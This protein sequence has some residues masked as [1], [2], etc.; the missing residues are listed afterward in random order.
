MKRYRTIVADP[1]WEYQ[2]GF[3]GW[4]R[5]RG[6]PYRSMSLEDIRALPVAEWLERE[7]YLFLWATSRHLEAAFSVVRA[8]NCTPRQTLTWCKP[9]DGAKGLGGMFYTNTEF[10]VVAQHIRA[11]TN[12]HG[13]RT[14]GDRVPSAWFEWPKQPHSRKPEAFLDLVERVS[15]GPYLE[16]F[17]RHKRLGW[18]AWGDEVDSDVEL[19]A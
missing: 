4:G 17:A 14:H 12:A 13:A 6:L 9:V 18:H 2:G 16:L 3:Q 5:R 1:P 8:W 7:G 15:P 19:V 11:G 10:V